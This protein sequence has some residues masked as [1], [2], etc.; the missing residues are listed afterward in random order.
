M[1]KVPGSSLEVREFELQM[2]YKVHF[3]KGMNPIMGLIAT[4]LSYY[5]N[6]FG[7]K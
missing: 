6:S 7:I 1:V 2:R 5:G 3:Q 4:L